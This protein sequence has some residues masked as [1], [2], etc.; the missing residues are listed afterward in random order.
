MKQLEWEQ[1]IY[2]ECEKFPTSKNSLFRFFE[3]FYYRK[4]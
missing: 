1:L 2:F 4:Q 3:Y